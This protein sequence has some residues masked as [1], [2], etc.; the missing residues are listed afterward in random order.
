MKRPFNKKHYDDQP[1]YVGGNYTV[2]KGGQ[3]LIKLGN[4]KKQA[5]V[6]PED[7]EYLNQFKW[8]LNDSGYAIYTQCFKKESGWRSRKLRMHRILLKV[9]K[10]QQ[11]DHVNGNRLDNRKSNLRICT[12]SQNTKNRI[13]STKNTSGYKGVWFKKDGKRLKRWVADIKVDYKK[14]S[15]GLFLTKEEAARAYNE[16]AK[17]YF[18]EFARLNNV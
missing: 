8:W 17:Q 15:L 13:K 11:I 14:I 16:A 6:D 10:G 12:Q 2:G 1:K 18:G 7:F 3:M 4:S 5:I 9:L